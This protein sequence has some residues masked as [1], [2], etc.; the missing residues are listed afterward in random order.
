MGMTANGNVY[1]CSGWQ[2]YILGNVK[3][4]SLK[5]IW[6]NSSGVKY[7]RGLRRKDFPKCLNCTDRGFCSMC[8]VRNANE[9]PSGDLFAI[10]KHFCEVAAINREIIVDWKAKQNV[11]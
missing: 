9:S 8:M 11:L 6:E 3:K 7:L 10:N 4:A 1:P 2:D 5:N